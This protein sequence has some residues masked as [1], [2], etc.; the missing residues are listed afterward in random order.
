MT[1]ARPPAASTAADPCFSRR[2]CLQTLAGSMLASAAGAAQAPRSVEWPAL[3]LIDGSLIAPQDWVGRPA[4][5][6]FW[7]TWC[8]FCKRHNAHVDKLFRSLDSSGPRVLGVALSADA[9]AVNSYMRDNGYLFPVVLD[10]GRLR[11]RFSDRRVLPMTCLID[12]GGRVSQCI[13]GEM[14]ESD[15]LGLPRSVAG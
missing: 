4:I 14:S 13:P 2:T 9:A 15:V 8:A 10:D 6:V 12:R 11:Q 7:A 1:E 5:V 3:R